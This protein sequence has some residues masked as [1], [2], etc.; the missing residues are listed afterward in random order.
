MPL[1]SAVA[2]DRAQRIVVGTGGQVADAGVDDGERRLV[3]LA[4]VVAVCV[5]RKR[6]S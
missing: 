5:Q 3:G 6:Y 1:L 2:E 4:V